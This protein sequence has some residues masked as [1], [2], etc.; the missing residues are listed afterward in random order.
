MNIKK[1][2]ASERTFFLL[3]VSLL[4]LFPNDLVKSASLRHHADEETDSW[5]VE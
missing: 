5:V 2:S 3:Y 1:D 4:L